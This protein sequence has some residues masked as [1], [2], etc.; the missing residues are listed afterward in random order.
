MATPQPGYLLGV[1]LG[2]SNTVAVIRWPDG[3]TRPLL[4]DGTPVMPSSVFVD[5]SGHIHVGR[6]AQRLAQTDPSRFEPNPKQRTDEQA[7]LL[8][9]REVPTVALLTAILRAVA[10]KAV[11]A[12]GF[13][14]PAILTYPVKWGSMR[15][16]MLQDAAAK[17]GFPPVHLVPEPIGAAHYFAQVMKQ[18]IPVGASVA[19]FDFG[20]GTLDIAVVRNEGMAGFQVLG[21]GGLKDLGGLDI[22][23]AL[24]EHLGRT[25][26]HNAPELWQR[27]VHPQSTTDK[28][29]RRQFWDDVRGAKEMLSRT[30][31]APV[32]VPGVDIS[33]HL[34]RDEL[35]RLATPLL[36]RAVIETQRV[37]SAASLTPQQLHGLFL[38]GG[39]SRIPLVSRMLHQKLGIAPIVLEQ[40]ELPVAEGALAAVPQ[41]QLHEPMSLA[42]T[43]GVPAGPAE[44]YTPPHGAESPH[45]MNAP[46]ENFLAPT[47][48]TPWWKKKSYWISGTAAL[49]VLV[50]A[51]WWILRDPYPQEPMHGLTDVGTVALAADGKADSYSRVD[52]ESGVAY[53]FATTGVGSTTG[54]VV[55]VEL[56]SG[57]EKWRTPV[58]TTSTW[59]NV[60]AENGIVTMSADN[61][62]DPDL[63]YVIDAEKGGVLSTIPRTSYDDFLV[64]G[65]RLIKR[66]EAAKKVHGYDASGKQVWSFDSEGD[67]SE[68]M[69]WE[70]AVEPA[71]SSAE[72][73]NRVYAKDTKGTVTVWETEK[74][75]QVGQGVIVKDA[76]ADDLLVYGDVVYVASG[77]NGYSLAAYDVKTMANIATIQ[78]D[79]AERTPEEVTVC[80]EQRICVREKAIGTDPKAKVT[81][82]DVSDGLKAEWTTPEEQDVKAVT[83]VGESLVIQWED[84]ESKTITNI[85]DGDFDKVGGDHFGSYTRIDSGS[86]LAYPWT[87]SPGASTITGLGA[88]DSNETV[89]GQ[90]DASACNADAMYLAC[91]TEAGY[92]VWKFR[93]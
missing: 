85:Y 35:E 17:A 29:G 9:D 16:D 63:M 86:L 4:V 57:K 68:A 1:D 11:E 65:D 48:T 28:R 77:A 92:K 53:Y 5:E 61:S 32:A 64:V 8:G 56:E 55:A 54:E 71:N 51:G 73:S 79:G 83:V 27:L 15:R 80:G 74:G 24:V 87:G 39:A 3:R 36:E 58:T 88:L 40:P 47:V 45:S 13:L 26:D 33:L 42:Q 23:E 46:P 90:V 37:I 14:P 62:A 19:V 52:I 50:I 2:T 59:G 76:T 34:T 49:L 84:S 6:D 60:W 72:E 38:V 93:D 12:I 67:V 91:V 78:L 70:T 7:I 69:I 82:V 21:D 18:P 31:V 81:V 30:T 41:H 25:I 66:E 10:D 89:L 44:P 20:G 75:E 22:D 43:S